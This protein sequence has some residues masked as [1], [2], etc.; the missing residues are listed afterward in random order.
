MFSV[1]QK[2]G[3]NPSEFEWAERPSRFRPQHPAPVLVHSSSS[4]YFQFD[5]HPREGQCVFFTP[6][7]GKYE[8]SQIVGGWERMAPYI[9]TWLNLL[10]AEVSQPDMWES[11]ASEKRLI[12]NVQPGKPDDLPF[13]EDE[14]KR[15]DKSLLEIKEYLGST[16]N[17]S[18]QQMK[19]ID[20]RLR[21]LGEA[22]QRMG[23]KDWGL[24]VVGVLTNIA[25]SAAFT[26]STSH[27]LFRFTGQVLD[28]VFRHRLFLPLS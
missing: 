28:W 23:R 11:L 17:L 13:N 4:H 7:V 6:G 24:L 20:A 2:V 21:Y 27:E 8:E 1:V 9:Y 15:I 10:K 16:Q 25:I 14:I 22:A 19:I 3:M 18:E 12:T 26:P 5:V